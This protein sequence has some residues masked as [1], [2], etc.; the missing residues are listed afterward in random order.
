MKLDFLALGKLTDSKANMRCGRKARDVTDL[1]P[2]V[3]V[4]GV[5][6]SLVVRPQIGTDLFEVVAGRRRWHAALAVAAE[7]PD[8]VPDHVASLPC[9]IIEPGDDAA[10]LEAS[11]LENM[12][13]LDP[14]EVKQWESFVA[15]VRKGR[16]IEEIAATFG[17]PEQAVRRVLALGNLLPRIRDLY[18]REEIDATT[19]RH[20]T[21]ASKTK[22]QEWLALF[23]DDYQRVPTGSYLR[24]WLLGGQSIPTN[25]ALFDLADYPGRIITTL[26]GDDAYFADAEAFWVAQDAAVAARAA[27]L[28]DAGWVDVVIV[29]PSEH[30]QSWEY[31]K[32][33]KRKGGKVYIDVRHSGEVT[34]HEGYLSRKDARKAE[35][36]ETG[37]SA[38]K[39]TR[40]EI[41]STMQ[42]YI[43]LHRHSA[44][45]AD[46][47]HH[48]MVALRLMAAHAITGSHLWRISP[49]P[50]SSR[51]ADVTE[52]AEG[53]PAE[54]AFDTERRAVLD[55]LGFSREEPT[56]TGGNQDDHGVAGLFLRLLALPDDVVLRLLPVIMGET[57]V[58]GSA[59]IEALGT[60]IGTDMA[61]WWTADSAFFDLLR[62]KAVLTRIVAEIAGETI[63]SA[64]A[65][66]KG[67]TLKRIACA[68]LDGEDGRTKVERWVPRWMRFAP[69]AYTDRGG[70]TT[71]TA[72]A[73]VET[74]RAALAEAEAAIEAEGQVPAEPERLAA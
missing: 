27:A 45:R 52:S 11:M 40:P 29:A 58:A 48:P 4:R 47:L 34:V 56:V 24:N 18:R 51:N 70:V 1:V 5:L 19:V 8:A 32:T 62:D 60:T 71:V 38:F 46:L 7:Q 55:L 20:L 6:Q 33:P 57:L 26:F 2:S 53:C 25:V 50:R 21:M 17:L 44:V 22:Q 42:A 54:A 12:V 59:A 69:S 39:T 64:N 30:F 61:N 66:E 36:G 63:A 31:E 16:N 43:D 10:A 49:D 3:R 13:R 23:D 68:H 65:D 28:L 14:D 15:L 37:A 35:R 74:A 73:K 41:T 9:A 67:K 72:H